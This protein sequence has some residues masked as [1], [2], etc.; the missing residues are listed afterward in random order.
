MAPGRVSR[1]IDNSAL[2][3]ILNKWLKGRGGKA[4]RHAAT[5]TVCLKTKQAKNEGAR[6]VEQ[7]KPEPRKEQI[8][9]T[10]VLWYLNGASSAPL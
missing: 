8:A 2:G 5:A 4:L 1:A 6:P 9:A 10:R 7:K 3:A